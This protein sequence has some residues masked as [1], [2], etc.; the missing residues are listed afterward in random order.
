[1]S[2]EEYILT[3]EQMGKE[4]IGVAKLGGVS[5]LISNTN[6]GDKVM[7]RITKVGPHLKA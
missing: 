6:P 3:I 5:I 1:M 4:G 2:E 7:V